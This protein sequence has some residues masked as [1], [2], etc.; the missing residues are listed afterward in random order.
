MLHHVNSNLD[1]VDVDR[2]TYDGFLKC[3]DQW[4][5]LFGV[6]TVITLGKNDILK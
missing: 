6:S 2:N 1:L 3:S 4:Q 5:Q